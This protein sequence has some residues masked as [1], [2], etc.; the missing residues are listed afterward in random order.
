MSAKP[1]VITERVTSPWRHGTLEPH[2]S[3]ARLDSSQLI[4][5]LSHCSYLQDTLVTFVNKRLSLDCLMFS[6]PL[7]SGGEHSTLSLARRDLFFRFY[8]CVDVFYTEVLSCL[9]F[10]IA[11]GFIGRCT[12][13]VHLHKCMKFKYACAKHSCDALH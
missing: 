10:C 2:P 3:Y 4:K 7:E 6:S 5:P 8:E 12:F 11:F 9:C 1:L 13:N